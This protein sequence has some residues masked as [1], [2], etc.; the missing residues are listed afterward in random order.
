MRID[1]SS[2][3][4]T[5]LL[6]VTPF[7]KPARLYK[8]DHRLS[9]LGTDV[10]PWKRAISMVRSSSRPGH[11]GSSMYMTHDGQLTGQIL[12][13]VLYYA[14]GIGPQVALLNHLDNLNSITN[15]SGCAIGINY[16]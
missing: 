9:L 11:K 12:R 3:R 14:P 7:Q 5:G 1:F 13:V 4:R 2:E 16:P 6:S 15:S 10:N 8:S